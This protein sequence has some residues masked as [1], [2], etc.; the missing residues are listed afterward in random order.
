[1]THS[2]GSRTSLL[3]KGWTLL[4]SGDGEKTT[5]GVAILVAPG[6]VPVHQVWGWILTVACA[7]GPNSNLAYPLEGVKL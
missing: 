1:M 7:Y 6:S 4:Y 3:G 5:G 2:K